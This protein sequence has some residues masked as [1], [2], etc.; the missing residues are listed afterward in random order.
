MERHNDWIP[1][2]R[3]TIQTDISLFILLLIIEWPLWISMY[4]KQMINHVKE[5]W[6]EETSGPNL[7]KPNFLGSTTALSVLSQA[8]HLLE[9]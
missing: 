5:E 3:R 7:L 6:R 1:S 4:S 2:K 9:G 8:L